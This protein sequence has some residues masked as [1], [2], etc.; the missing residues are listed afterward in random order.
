MSHSLLRK[1]QLSPRP[2]GLCSP[3]CTYIAL[4]VLL[5]TH[6]DAFICHGLQGPKRPATWSLAT[7]D[8]QFINWSLNLQVE[9][10]APDVRGDV[11]HR[12]PGS[13]ER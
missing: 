4:Q 12:L 7:R 3:S 9:A 6:I 5:T 10:L 1:G 8:P 2:C 13:E 11:N